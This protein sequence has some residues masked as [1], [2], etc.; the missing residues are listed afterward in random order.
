MATYSIRK[1]KH[2]FATKVTCSVDPGGKHIAYTVLDESGTAMSTTHISHGAKEI[3]DFLVRMM[4]DQLR[5][6]PRTL[7]GFF[8]CPIDGPTLR[9]EMLTNTR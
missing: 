8:N 5:V 7:K 2:A 9:A 1:V 4:A 3:D 6:R